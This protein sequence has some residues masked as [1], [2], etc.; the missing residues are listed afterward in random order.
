MGNL[1]EGLDRENPNLFGGL[2]FMLTLVFT[3]LDKDS[4]IHNHNTSLSYS[5]KISLN[6]LNIRG[7]SDNS[8]FV[9]GRT[10]WTNTGS[11]PENNKGKG[12]SVGC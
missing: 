3:S 8:D 7:G 4:A 2:I 9:P 6:S 11:T 10:P 5:E 12:F 1:L